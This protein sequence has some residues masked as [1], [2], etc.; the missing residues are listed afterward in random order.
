MAIYKTTILKTKQA[1]E[2]DSDKLDDG[3]YAYALQLGMKSILNRLSKFKKEDYT[4]EGEFNTAVMAKVE[5]T[6]NAAYA[7]EHGGTGGKGIRMVGTAK[8]PKTGGAEKVEARRI[9]REIV[10]SQLKA[11]GEKLSQYSAK[12]ITEAADALIEANPEILAEAKEN[13]TKRVEKAEKLKVNISAISKSGKAPKAKAE[14]APLSAK[15]AGIPMERKPAP[16][17]VRH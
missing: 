9:A 1:V 7:T 2:W 11:A 16:A 15:Q 6:V 8:G 12:D 10:K 17:H 4:S 13:L 5:E 14:K 3:V